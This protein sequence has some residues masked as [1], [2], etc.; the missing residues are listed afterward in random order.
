M[1]KMSPPFLARIASIVPLT[2][3]RSTIAYRGRRL[4]GTENK[5]TSVVEATEFLGSLQPRF[6]S[7]RN[8]LFE[9]VEPLWRAKIILNSFAVVAASHGDDRGR[10]VGHG[11]A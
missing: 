5:T 11:S 4:E 7:L 2:S 1:E 10:Q 8:T 3:I 6:S 9:I